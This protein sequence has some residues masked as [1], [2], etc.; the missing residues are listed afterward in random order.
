MLRLGA[1]TYALFSA[2]LEGL[3]ASVHLVSFAKQNAGCLEALADSKDAEE[4][5]NSKT[6]TVHKSSLVWSIVFQLYPWNCTKA[7]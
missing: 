4:W 2:L 3:F 6:N 1:E 5:K 7:T